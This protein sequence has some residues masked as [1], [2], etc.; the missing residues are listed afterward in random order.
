MGLFQLEQKVKACQ[1]DVRAMIKSMGDE[2]CIEAEKQ[3]TETIA[4]ILSHGYSELELKEWKAQVDALFAKVT[5]EVQ[6]IY[7]M[8]TD[9]KQE[10]KEQ[11]SRK[12]SMFSQMGSSKEEEVEFDPV[13]TIE[14]EGAQAHQN[15]LMVI[16]SS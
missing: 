11:F 10:R 13:A 5:S 16:N 14:Q 12:L 15:D 2:R 3:L 4:E 1:K 8:M 6:V 9:A 7:K